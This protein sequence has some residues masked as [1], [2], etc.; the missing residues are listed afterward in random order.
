MILDKDAISEYKKIYFI[1]HGEQITDEQALD[2]GVR[3]INF[4][5]AVFGPNQPKSVWERIR[6]E[7]NKS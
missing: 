5:K 7:Y 4:I 6:K 2:E 3:L 1:V